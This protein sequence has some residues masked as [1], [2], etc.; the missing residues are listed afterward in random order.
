MRTNEKQNQIDYYLSQLEKRENTNLKKKIGIGIGASLI[1]SLGI[2]YF[3]M[4][5][6][7]SSNVLS[8]I[9]IPEKNSV[10]VNLSENE[11]TSPEV[12]E[13]AVL[14]INE[15]PNPNPKSIERAR[16]ELSAETNGINETIDRDPV[17]TNDRNPVNRI[18]QNTA[19]EQHS[20]REVPTDGSEE[21]ASNAL[22]EIEE[23]PRSL[24]KVETVNL[25]VAEGFPIGAEPKGV[26]EQNTIADN[27]SN[28]IPNAVIEREI[29]T[30]KGGDASNKEEK[31]IAKE[32][33]EKEI[34]PKE[35]KQKFIPPSFPGGS[36]SLA[37]F[38]NKKISYPG[39]A[40]DNRIEGVVNVSLEIDE[41]GKIG[42]VA[43]IDG[44]GN[45][46]EEEVL[47]AIRKM[48]D[49]VPA[50]VDNVPTKRKYR[51]AV[52]FKLPQ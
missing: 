20:T 40:L 46:C 9:T 10:E 8:S 32:E 52:T 31:P 50:T 4:D 45:G 21:F 51:L 49:W 34:S 6:N 26:N 11:S 18:L 44:I 22:N 30:E 48:P 39:V 12:E 15:A 42:E 13:E 7:N 17:T 24:N 5:N 43:I 41:K 33:D 47:K 28:P 14:V 38:L 29:L 1:F 35:K 19:E 37:K 16:N 2:G 3:I 27:T 23:K 36:K 25:P